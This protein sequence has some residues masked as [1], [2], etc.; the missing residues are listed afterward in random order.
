MVAQ[1]GFVNG[2]DLCFW[3]LSLG[4]DCFFYKGHG[5]LLLSFRDLDSTTFSKL[6]ADGIRLGR[7]KLV[8]FRRFSV[9]D[10]T[11]GIDLFKLYVKCVTIYYNMTD[12]Q[13]GE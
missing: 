8:W 7:K 4:L 1:C 3:G 13:R 5:G 2:I 10:K 11:T 12:L 9:E 6:N